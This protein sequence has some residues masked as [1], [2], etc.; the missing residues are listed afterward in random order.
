M[1]AVFTIGL[2]GFLLDRVMLTAAGRL[3]AFGQPVTPMAILE[4][5]KV[6]KSYG[7]GAGR[8][9]VLKD[10]SLAIEEGEFVAIVG[11]SGAGKTTLI[12]VIAGLIRRTPARCCSGTHR[13]A[14]RAGARARVP[15]LFAD[16][17]ADGRGQHCAGGGCHHAARHPRRAGGPQALYRA[18]RAV[19]CGRPA[20]G[21][22]VRRHAPARC[23]GARAGDEAGNP[24]AR[25]AAVGAR[26]AH[27]RQAA[28]RDRRD[29]RDRAQDDRARHQRCRRGAAAGRPHHPADARPERDARH[30][31]PGDHRAAARPRRAQP[32]CRI[33]AAARRHHAVPDGSGRTSPQHA[34]DRAERAQDRADPPRRAAQEEPARRAAGRPS[35][36]MWS[37][38]TSGRSIRRPRGR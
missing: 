33:P 10:V 32:R 29:L 35:S 23:G 28:G 12:S 25:R 3:H 17:V 16:A 2:I 31:V 4:L 26:C 19:S 34:R 22:A 11:F 30:R 20:A 24:A 13:S 36:A 5:N 8:M 37:S 6:G 1:V 15:E 14:S 18:G 7:A 27:P 9:D 21:R 38:T